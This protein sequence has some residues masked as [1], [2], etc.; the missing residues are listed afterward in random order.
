MENTP[1]T[2]IALAIITLSI[3]A[4]ST[5][6]PT[7]SVGPAAVA[8]PA[9]AAGQTDVSATVTITGATSLED[10]MVHWALGRFKAAGLA[11]P[12]VDVVFHSDT[13]ACLDF[14]GYYSSTTSR[15]DICNRDDQSTDPKNTVLHELAHAWSFAHMTETDIAD[16]V[17][18]RDLDGWDSND[19]AWWKM[20]QEQAAE[21]IAWGLQGPNEYQSIWIHLET[22]DD[23][24][25]DFELLTGTPP[26][27]TNTRYCK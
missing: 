10:E 24:A 12:Q 26:L 11:L 13:T 20:G 7:A 1:R 3:A 6:T 4:G 14:I 5:V 9:A 16:F 21:I 2:R 19:L 27:H 23:L 17:T 25:A 22:C 18:H 8:N 15:V